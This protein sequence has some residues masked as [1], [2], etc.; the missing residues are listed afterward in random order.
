MRRFAVPLLLLLL[1]VLLV[2]GCAEPPPPEPQK[3]ELP[4]EPSPEQI[5]GELKNAVQVLWQPLDGGGGIGTDTRKQAVDNFRAQKGKVPSSDNGRK[6]LSLIQR[7]IEELVRKGRKEERWQP[8]KGGIE[9]YKILQPGNDR[10]DKLEERAD[11]MLKRPKAFLRGFFDVEGELYAFIEVEDGETKVRTRYE[12]REG[13]EFH[14]I[15]R[16]VR[17]VGNQQAI[18]VEYL[19]LHTTWE[20]KG[21]RESRMPEK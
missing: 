1:V 11:L 21:P 18:E 3:P 7:D 13:E 19:P 10:Y 6:A 14:G 12:V 8:V 9:I 15:L 5:R 16:L 4:P 2:P 20:V 17:I